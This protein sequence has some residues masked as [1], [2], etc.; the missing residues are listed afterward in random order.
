MGFFYLRTMVNVIIGALIG[1]IGGGVATFIIQ[2]TMLKKRKEQILKEADLEG[3][4]MKKEKILQAKERF[5]KLKEEHEENVKERERRM[6]STEDR[7]KSKEK[8]LTQKIEEVSRKEKDTERMQAELA[9][10][11][12]ANEIRHQELDK[13]HFGLMEEIIQRLKI[14]FL[15]RVNYTQYRLK[16]E[17]ITVLKIAI[18]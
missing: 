1:L 10:K 8:S 4:A 7:V 16:M 12:E 3:E 18:F 2:N 13:M 5:L 15:I 6:Q 11:L 17:G 14:V 9:S